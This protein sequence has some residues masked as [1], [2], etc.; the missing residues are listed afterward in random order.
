MRSVC[1]GEIF[2]GEHQGKRYCVLHFPGG[3]TKFW[4]VLDRKLDRNDLDFRGVWFPGPWP[5]EHA[6][7]A[8]DAN[9]SSAH[10]ESEVDFTGASF[11]GTADFSGATFKSGAYLDRKSTRLN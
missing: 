6:Q 2:Y 11:S 7:F 4:D 5:S 10:F 8:R 3:K 9:F 1:E